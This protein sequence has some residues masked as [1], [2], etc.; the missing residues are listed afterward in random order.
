LSLLFAPFFAGLLFFSFFSPSF[1]AGALAFVAGFSAPFLAGL[2]FFSFFAAFLAGLLFFFFFFASLFFTGFIASFTACIF[3][4]CVCLAFLGFTTTFF[5]FGLITL[6]LCAGSFFSYFDTLVGSPFPAAPSFLSAT[7]QPEARGG[8]L[9]LTF[10]PPPVFASARSFRHH[11]AAFLS[12]FLK[13]LLFLK[14]EF[15]FSSPEVPFCVV[16]PIST[17][18]CG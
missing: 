8:T 11:A 15:S 17:R 3:C 14:Y 16:S 12:S 9:P 10:L 2:L 5:F 13:Y 7:F 1:L 18:E 6:F 4:C